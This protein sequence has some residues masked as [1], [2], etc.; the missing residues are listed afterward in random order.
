MGNIFIFIFIFPI[1]CTIFFKNFIFLSIIASLIH[2]TGTINFK[3]TSSNN[4]QSNDDDR[5]TITDNSNVTQNDANINV[6]ENNDSSNWMNYV[7]KQN[8][9]DISIE[10][11]IYTGVGDSYDKQQ[12]N[13]TVD[14]LKN[15]FDNLKKYRLSKIYYIGVGYPV[16]DIL[17]ITYDINDTAYNLQIAKGEIWLAEEIN[18]TELIAALDNSIY[19][20]VNEN[21]KNESTN[22]HYNYRLEGFNNSIYDEYFK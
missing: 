13:I 16:G 11:H 8:I 20:S 1:W 5:Q 4:Q 12:K 17:T 3:N 6:Y 21:V 2:A 15:I 19:S 14:Q 7:L 18:D 9:T 10:R 22:Y